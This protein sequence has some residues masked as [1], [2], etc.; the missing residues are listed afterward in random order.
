MHSPVRRWRLTEWVG[1]ISM[2]TDWFDHVRVCVDTQLSVRGVHSR[3]LQEEPSVGGVI[4]IIIWGGGGGDLGVRKRVKCL[5]TCP[6]ILHGKIKNG[7]C[8]SNVDAIGIMYCVH[9]V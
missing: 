7:H 3:C 4:I 1:H 8:R 5:A 2:D 6:L 9:T